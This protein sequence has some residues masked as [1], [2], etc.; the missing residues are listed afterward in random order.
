MRE[1]ITKSSAK[2]KKHIWMLNNFGHLLSSDYVL[3]FSNSTGRS[4][5]N[6][7]KN[8]VLRISPC[9]SPIVAPNRVET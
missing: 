4:F 2:S 5:I 7:L 9:L 8:I 6:K 3:C 1:Y